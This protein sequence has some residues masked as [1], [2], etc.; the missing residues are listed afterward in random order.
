[1]RKHSLLVSSAMILAFLLTTAV[2]ARAA[3]PSLGT[4]KLN[5]AQSKFPPNQPGLAAPKQET[6]VKRAVGDNFEVTITG[7]AADGSPM[8]AK[9]TQPQQGG[10]IK[11]VQG[12]LP[13]GLS[14]VATVI[15]PGEFYVTQ[16]Q[17]GKQVQVEHIVVSK[18]G[19]TMRVNLHRIDA[20]GH[21]SQAIEVWDKQ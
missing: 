16:L 5:L 9:I 10:V 3:E 7:I 11:F 1:M 19:K 13:E 18:D 8:A 4:W 14:E 17:D 21:A 15:G 6:V 2:A 20:Q 12:G